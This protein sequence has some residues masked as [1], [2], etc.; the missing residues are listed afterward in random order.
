MMLFS[1][2]VNFIETLIFYIQ[3]LCSKQQRQ[4]FKGLKCFSGFLN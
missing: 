3:I 2:I 4:V 1:I